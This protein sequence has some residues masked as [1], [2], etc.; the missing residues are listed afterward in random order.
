MVVPFHITA[1]IELTCPATLP[2]L[3]L[4]AVVVAA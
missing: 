3:V 2:G 4:V 1:W